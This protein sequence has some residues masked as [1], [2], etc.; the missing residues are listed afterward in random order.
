MTILECV[1][2][3]KQYG[4]GESLIHAVNDISFTVDKGEF[5]S[6]VGTSGSGK[7][8]LLHMIGGVDRPTEG[9]III[10]G[11]DITALKEDDLAVFRRR[12]I[13]LVYQFYNLIQVLDAD[14]NILLPSL[15]DG[16]AEDRE[17]LDSIIRYLDLEDRRNHLP[18]ELSGGQQQRVSIGR[19]LY[20][21]PELLLCDEPTGNL[22]SKASE[23]VVRLLQKANKER[24]QTIILVTH[25]E[26]IAAK[27]DRI[28]TLADGRI[29]R[30]TKVSA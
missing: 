24:G 30:D 5:V 22:D 28:I 15:L 3:R 23:D 14:E 7:S 4:T 20:S 12:K 18:R 13:G 25:D 29:I 6:I 27:A 21:E 2:L 1:D 8:T 9:K 17:K 26:S 10:G 19:A 16:H 11:T